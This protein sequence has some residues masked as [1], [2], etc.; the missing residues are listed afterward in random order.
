VATTRL[1]S[2]EADWILE[3]GPD[4]AA[5][6]NEAAGYRAASR[7]LD[8]QWGILFNVRPDRLYFDFLA[9]RAFAQCIDHEGLATALD[10]E[11]HVAVAPYTA[12][13]W[14]LAESSVR[15]RDVAAANAQLDEAGWE[16]APDGVR[17]RDG[18]RLSSTIAVRP[19]AIHLFTFANEAREQLIECGIE[20]IVEELDLT[21]NTMLDQLQWPNEFDTLLWQRTLT[22][23]PD[24]AVRVF[25][26]SRITSDENQADENPSGFRSDLVDHLVATARESH[27]PKQRAEDY[28]EV[29]DE[30]TKLL[31]YW[32]LWY[33]S[34]TAA[35]SDRLRGPDGPIDPSRSRYDWNIARWSFATDI[36]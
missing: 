5:T 31:P 25:E 28:A 35:V 11:R 26:S 22:P 18:V 9:R 27:D 6:I 14:A 3:T 13:S 33:D 17:V 12:E 1:L 36:E 8:R 4:Q 21:G 16:M 7:A 30:L 29:Q 20:L 10:D 34:A 2:G 24:S 23:D 32:P 19:T 15:P